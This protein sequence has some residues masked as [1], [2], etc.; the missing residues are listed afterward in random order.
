VKRREADATARLAECERKEHIIAEA[1][2]ANA[3]AAAA[4]QKL[5]AALVLVRQMSVALEANHLVE[6][7]DNLIEGT[8]QHG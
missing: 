1:E 7:F 3:E 8:M 5:R 2:K 4:A 6:K